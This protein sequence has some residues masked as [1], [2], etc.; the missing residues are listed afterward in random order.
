M[1]YFISRTDFLS[2]IHICTHILLNCQ[3]NN[4]EDLHSV[5]DSSKLIAGI[6]SILYLSALQRRAFSLWLLLLCFIVTMSVLSY[7]ILIRI[8]KNFLFTNSASY[9]IFVLSWKDALK[10]IPKFDLFHGF[11]LESYKYGKTKVRIIIINSQIVHQILKVQQH[12]CRVI[13]LGPVV[14]LN[15]EWKHLESKNSSF[16]NNFWMISIVF[17]FLNLRHEL[18]KNVL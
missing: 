9:I 4:H 18:H 12:C 5:P 3:H 7:V 2:K 8:V 11:I 1:F 16:Q 14:R 15:I 17:D 10:L 6:I 13:A